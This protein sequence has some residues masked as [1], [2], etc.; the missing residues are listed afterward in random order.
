MQEDL[1]IIKK[2]Y[3]EAM[4]QL[5]R[6]LF[7]SILE[8][9]GLLSKLMLTHFYES[10]F[11]YQDIV[12]K[13]YVE[14]FKN[15]I[16]GLLTPK[17]EPVVRLDKTPKELFDEAGYDFYECHNEQDIDRFREYYASGEELCTFD[18]HRLDS[19]FVFF[20]VK[21]DVDKIHREDFLN[22]EREDEYG[23]S[24]LSIQFMRD[25]KH[26]LSIKNRYNYTVDNP[27]ATFSNN[28][29]N[30]IP[31]LTEAFHQTYGLRERHIVEEF[32]LFGYIKA[33]D[34][35]YYKYNYG[36]N[37]VY[38]CPDNIIIDALEVKKFEREKYLVMDYFV[39]DL[40]NKKISSY[41]PKKF[42]SFPDSIQNIKRITVENMVDGKKVVIETEDGLIEIKLNPYNQIVRYFN[43]AAKEIGNSFLQ[44]N[45][46][47]E[48]LSM[49]NV[50]VVGDNLLVLNNT[51][52]SLNMPSVRE[53]G[54]DP[55]QMNKI[56]KT[57]CL[58]KVEVIGNACMNWNKELKVVD[59]PSLVRVGNSFLTQAKSLEHVY[60]P[61]LVEVGE[62]CNPVILEQLS[63]NEERRI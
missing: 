33:N 4:M 15:Y 45:T 18:S 55:L 8:V 26:S 37:N 12:N 30:I 6:K 29:D 25:K 31:G 19:C 35:K 43:S 50:E 63:L 58:P 52:S 20:A 10:R 3:G 16:Y 61:N 11:L 36:I 59:A 40:Q 24:V 51:L 28:L 17:E 27:D 14:Q 49:P 1:K 42:D 46:T 9:E 57:F 13:N 34:G 39:L 56:L 38:Y 2:K 44:Y 54:K 48:E 60:T 23:T 32:R 47:I 7:P 41:D 21:K 53:L 22:P 5:C 62:D